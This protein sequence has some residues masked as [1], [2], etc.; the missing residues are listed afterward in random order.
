MRR[1]IRLGTLN[2]RP[3]RHL[4]T[5]YFALLRR[6][7]QSLECFLVQLC[8]STRVLVVLAG[9]PRFVILLQ[10]IGHQSWH[11]A[12][13]RLALNRN[14]DRIILLVAV[15]VGQP[16]LEQRVT[17]NL[18]ARKLN[19]P[20]LL[21]VRELNLRPVS[22]HMELHAGDQVILILLPLF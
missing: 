14:L 4:S 8:I 6:F 17:E 12:H 18:L 16:L 2:H 13:E 10:L 1:H 7:V 15:L 19:F 20:D 5:S 21:L 9:L 11:L 3:P 22:R